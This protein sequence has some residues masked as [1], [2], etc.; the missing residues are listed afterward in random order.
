MTTLEILAIIFGIIGII[1]S[2]IPAIPGPP[3]SWV[4][5]LF[6]YLN[7]SG[8]TSQCLWILFAV[9]VVVTILDFV[10]PSVFTKISGG[11]KYASLGAIVGL[12]LGLLFPIIPLGMIGGSMMCA[13]L[14]ELLGADRSVGASFKAAIFAFLSFMLTTG[15]KLIVSGVMLYYIVVNISR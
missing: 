6:V 4:G 1:G 8:M 13:F 7:K 3:L 15:L 12:F 10:L 14:F 5:I 2:I 9:M 11:S